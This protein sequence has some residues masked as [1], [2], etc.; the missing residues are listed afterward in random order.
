MNKQEFLKELGK[1]LSG[2][3]KADADERLSFYS[4]MID[5][6]IEEGLSEEK[7]VESVGSVA[8]IA[9][10]ILEDTT[11][12]SSTKSEKAQNTEKRKSKVWSI[13]LIC[14]GSPIWISLGAAFFSVLIAIYACLWA[15]AGS[16]WAIPTA[17][18]ACAPA[19][20]FALVIQCIEGNILSGLALLGMGIFAAGLSTF[21]TFGCLQATKGTVALSK[22]IFL[23]L[24]SLFA[25]KESAQ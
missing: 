3:S 20:I 13:V 19:S 24:R 25:R 22:I 1:R 21:A 15:V 7:A 11:T 17:L 16:L 18:I 2:I 4:E 8:E 23:W 9:A 5:D 14:V 12:V 6:R 10:Q